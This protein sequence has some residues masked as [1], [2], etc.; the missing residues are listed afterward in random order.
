M[1]VRLLLLA[2]STG[3]VGLIV[4]VDS[5]AM[6]QLWETVY[7]IPFGDKVG[8]FVLMGI[9]SVLANLSLNCRELRWAGRPVMLGTLIVF[10]LV[11]GEEISQAFIATRTCDAADFLADTAGILLGAMA[12]KHYSRLRSK[13]LSFGMQ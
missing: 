5:G 2:F 8:H 7:A 11:A 3:L 12:A 1:A 13:P 10:V 4:S 9:F 6:P